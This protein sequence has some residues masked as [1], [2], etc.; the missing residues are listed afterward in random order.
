MSPVSLPLAQPP[1]W[2]LKT[3]ILVV[4]PQTS[5]T[6]IFDSKNSTEVLKQNIFEKSFWSLTGKRRLPT[7]NSAAR[8][9][10]R[11]HWRNNKH[12]DGVTHSVEGDHDKTVPFTWIELRGDCDL[13][14]VSEWLPVDLA[15]NIEFQFE[16]LNSGMRYRSL[17][18]ISPTTC[19]LYKRAG[20]RHGHCLTS[21]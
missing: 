10:F 15:S 16:M 1:S 17:L 5:S 12:Q 14:L 18:G 3:C 2:E 13:K 9:V 4:L 21:N 11:S 7:T 6:T 8:L 19:H 20:N